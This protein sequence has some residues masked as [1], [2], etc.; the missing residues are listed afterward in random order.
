MIFGGAL[1]A[2]SMLAGTINQ[3]DVTLPHDVTVGSVVLPTGHYTM[4]SFEM[5]GEQ[6][7]VVRGDNG[8]TA[9]LPAQ[10]V[11]NGDSA[12]KTEVVFSK[13]GDT[14]RFDKLTV[15][16]DGQSYQFNSLK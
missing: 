2:G 10:T 15:A 11:L 5:G 4:N 12:A 13:S 7:F 14:W 16:G 1:I 6:V 8:K 9:T 3:I